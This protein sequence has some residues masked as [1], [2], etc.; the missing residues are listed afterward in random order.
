MRPILTAEEMRSADAWAIAH[1]VPGITL[2]ENAG[3]AA[4]R[5]I[6]SRFGRER[7]VAIVCGLGNNGGDGFVVARV[8]KSDWTRVYVIGD[9]E[10][11]RGDAKHHYDRL[12]KERS[13]LPVEAIKTDAEWQA[14]A[15]EFG[16]CSLI[17]D[18]LL[19]TGSHD[20]PRD[21]TALAIESVRRER[22]RGARV[23]SVDLPS[24]VPADG[25]P[26]DWKTIEADVTVTFAAKKPCH[27]LSPVCDASGT[28][29]VAPI[30]IAEEGLQFNERGLRLREVEA[31]DARAAYPA[32]PKDGHKGT[33]G[34]VLIVAGSVGKAGA[35][36][37][38]ARGAFRAGAG[39]VT[40]ASVNE[41]AR[42]VN[43]VQ[44]EVM[45]LP[46]GEG[47]ECG[48]VAKAAARILELAASVD[49]IVLGPGLGRSEKT[50][51]F[52]LE[53]AGRSGLP[54]VIDADGLFGLRA[55]TLSRIT[56]RDAPTVLTPH[57]GEMG[58]LMGLETADVQKDRIRAV[59]RAASDTR[60]VVLLKGRH[61][62]IGAANGEVWL[63][64]TGSSALATAGTGDVLAG[65]IGAICARGVAA[66]LAAAAGCYVHGLA[67]ERAG[68]RKPWGVIA[69]D[70]ADALP[71][72]IAS[73]V[74]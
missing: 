12:R 33:F 45:T 47:V 44:P 52:A 38:A 46:L 10:K 9:P 68:A 35:A 65:A 22:A 55:Q 58:R 70:V 2:M 6:E 24:G 66:D 42:A 26:F 27:V 57:P 51:A 3:L 69:G 60:A 31:A 28:V 25:G 50:Q 19:G 49:S 74:R 29:V 37:L 21:L 72:A 56:Q 32:R 16:R 4:A 59:R 62:L 61:S 41:V 43:A 53:I 64:P 63:N 39:L 67:G 73:V 40:V 34:H 5:A 71:K 20:A 11:L 7:R 23:V 18:A 14:K 48:D 36:I 15:T 8:L 30:G 13:R 17:V 54:L 1:G